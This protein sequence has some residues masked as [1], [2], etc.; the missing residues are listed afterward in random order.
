MDSAVLLPVDR[1][2]VRWGAPSYKHFCGSGLGLL[3]S[4]SDK[5]CALFATDR[6]PS[7][8]YIIT[9]QGRRVE[10]WRGG[11][12]YCLTQLVVVVVVLVLVVAASGGGGQLAGRKKGGSV[13]GKLVHGV[14]LTSRG[15]VG[16]VWSRHEVARKPTI[17][18]ILYYPPQSTPLGQTELTRTKSPRTN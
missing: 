17:I 10:G 7:S 4:S 8:T 2:Y 13:M 14:G 5:K 3:F 9:W 16:R 15:W 12:W 11:G 6:T 18:K 1:P